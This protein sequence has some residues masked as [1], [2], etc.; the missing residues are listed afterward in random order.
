MLLPAIIGV[1]SGL[2]VTGLP[3]L[4]MAFWTALQAVATILA[5][6]AAAIYAAIAYQQTS[7]IVRQTNLAEK[8]YLERNKPVVFVDRI[9]DLERTRNYRYVIRNAG[10]GYAVNVYYYDIMVVAPH[11]VGS[12]AAGEHRLVPA[13]LNDYLCRG[14]AVKCVI[15]A[16]APY[17]RTTQ[18]TVTL[19]LRTQ[20]ASGH[21]GQVL[22]RAAR[23]TYEPPRFRDESLQDFM[24]AN[25]PDIRQQ[26]RDLEADNLAA[27]EFLS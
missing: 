18:W 17:T 22:H 24:T 26:L 10:G 19:N 8:D 21:E 11:A 4:D 15:V 7:A 20:E 16:E 6:I 12:L 3:E 27:P 1:L 14:G 9:D 2:V 25:G 23:V 13:D 5:F